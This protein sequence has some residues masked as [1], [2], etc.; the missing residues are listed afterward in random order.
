LTAPWLHVLAAVLD[1]DVDPT[2]VLLKV[3]AHGFTASL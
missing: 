1:E 3:C 2:P